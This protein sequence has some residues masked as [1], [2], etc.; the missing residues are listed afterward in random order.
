MLCMSKTPSF[1]PLLSDSSDKQQQLRH[2]VYGSRTKGFQVFISRK[3]RCGEVFRRV[4][5]S[6]QSDCRDFIMS[7][8][9]S[10]TAAGMSEDSTG[11]V[12]AAVG[13]VLC[14][15]WNQERWEREGQGEACRL[16]LFS[17]ALDFLSVLPHVPLSLFLSPSLTQKTCFPPKACSNINSIT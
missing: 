17:A 10:Q 1:S 5:Y 7:R 9:S 14:P 8:Q 12:E 2:V 6:F 15:L 4:S 13:C 3:S 11:R 16:L